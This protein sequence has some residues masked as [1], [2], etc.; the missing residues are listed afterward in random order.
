MVQFVR[1][2][3]LTLLAVLRS[4]PRCSKAVTSLVTME[5]AASPSTVSRTREEQRMQASAGAHE[6]HIQSHGS[7][8]S[9]AR[10]SLTRALL[11][12]WSSGEKFADEKYFSH[13][14]RAS[15]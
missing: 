13:A 6:W 8:W 14:H 4:V 10:V 2:L 15:C 11:L 7:R 5:L 9:T 3:A 1:L 12:P